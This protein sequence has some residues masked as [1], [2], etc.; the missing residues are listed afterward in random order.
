MGVYMGRVGREG[1]YGEGEGWIEW[2]SAW[3][4]GEVVYGEWAWGCMESG[5][6]GVWRVGEGVYGEV[7]VWVY[8][9]GAK[10]CMESGRGGVWEIGRGGVW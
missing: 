3:R 9:E 1:V 7:G 4:V 2:A 8:G 10:G 6:G 5:R